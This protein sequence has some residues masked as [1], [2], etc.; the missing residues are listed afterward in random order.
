MHVFLMNRVQGLTRREMIGLGAAASVGSMGLIGCQRSAPPKNVIFLVT[1]GMSSGVPILAEQYSQRVRKV[2]THLQRMMV[3]PSTAKGFFETGTLDSLVTDSAGASSAWSSGQKVCNR[4]L[5]TYPD[6]TE[7]VSL[8]PLLKERGVR[9]G[10][11]TTARMTHATPAGF[12]ASVVRRD[13]EDEIAVQYLDRVDVLLGGGAVHFDPAFRRDGRD[14]MAEFAQKGYRVVTSRQDLE[15]LSPGDRTLGLFGADHLP[16]TIDT[17]KSGGVPDDGPTLAQMTEAALKAL[18]GRQG[19][20]LMV[21]AA[22]VDHAAH[23]NDIGGLIWDQLAFDDAI[24]SALTFQAAHPDTLVVVAT[25]HGNANPGLNGMGPEYRDSTATFERVLRQVDSFER[26]RADLRKSLRMNPKPG[27]QT[28]V[29]RVASGLGVVINQDEARHLSDSLQPLPPD[30]VLDQRRGFYRL[31]G[32]M[33]GSRTGVGWSSVVHTSDWAMV[34]ATGP[35]QERF[36]VL[37]PSTGF[38][39]H[40]AEIYGISHRNPAFTG[41]LLVPEVFEDSFIGPMG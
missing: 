34:V 24:G 30:Q 38:F 27:L 33:H 36:G 13:F 41:T 25:D 5:N 1:D 28:V 15:R 17:R 29:D 11:V 2:G 4:A 39:G 14:L 7:L 8:I 18:R 32:L 26:I 16:Y 37:Q 20:F 3:N 19:F 31:L 9:T 35:E 22:R 6:G 23:A 10:L 12:A 21:E 40:M